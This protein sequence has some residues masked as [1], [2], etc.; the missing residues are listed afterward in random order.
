LNAWYGYRS[1]QLALRTGLEDVEKLLLDAGVEVDVTDR[2]RLT[3]FQVVVRQKTRPLRIP[4]SQRELSDKRHLGWATQRTTIYAENCRRPDKLT[5]AKMAKRQWF[6]A[7][8]KDLNQ[9][10]GR[11]KRDLK[12][13]CSRRSDAVG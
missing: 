2:N 12:H 9:K 7:G 3:S 8:G 10:E 5:S 1:L 11:L 6:L 4:F 13:F